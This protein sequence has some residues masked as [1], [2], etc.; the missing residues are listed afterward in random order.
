MTNKIIVENIGLIY[1]AMK[2]L[3]CNMEEEQ[4]DEY[5]FTG[6]M[7][8]YKGIK[9]YDASKGTKPST[10]YYKCISTEIKVLFRT[11]KYKKHL[12]NKAISLNTIVGENLELA[13]IIQSDY[14]IE[15][16]TIKKVMIEDVINAINKLK[17]KKYKQCL[18]EYYGINR[19]AL[20]M[21]KIAQKYGI[22][23]QCVRQ[24]IQRGLELLRKEL[25]K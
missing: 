4:K 25:K 14:D 2:D 12:Y 13:D 1:K 23:A 10:Y 18:V 7:G 21:P 11:K 3:H 17:S 6:L 9:T 8:L 16:E 20:S 24:Y 19:S 5:F 22:T 15:E